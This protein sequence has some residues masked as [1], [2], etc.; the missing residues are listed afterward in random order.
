MRILV[1]DEWTHLAGQ[2][3]VEEALAEAAVAVAADAVRGGG[4]VGV[5]EDL[6]LGPGVE[7]DDFGLV[8]DIGLNRADVHNGIDVHCTD[9][10]LV[11][12]A[13]DLDGLVAL[14]RGEAVLA[15]ECSIRASG[16]E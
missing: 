15:A 2:A 5:R 8:D 6:G 11:D 9:D 4:G 14:M 16:A 7:E 3:A 1:F 10:V 13:S 12:V